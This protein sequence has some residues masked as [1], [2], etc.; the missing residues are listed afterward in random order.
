MIAVWILTAQ[1]NG[2]FAM[3][4]MS[5]EAACVAAISGLSQIVDAAE[6][7][8]AV[9]LPPHPPGPAPE[10]APIPPKRP[11]VTV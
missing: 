2:G 8:E 11:G 9:V 3:V 4:P 7:F 10:I 6:C 1:I 5:S